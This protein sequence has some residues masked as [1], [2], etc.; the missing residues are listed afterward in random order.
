MDSLCRSASN[1]RKDPNFLSSLPQNQLDWLK[2]NCPQNL[3]I[4]FLFCIYLLLYATV[5]V[6]ISFSFYL[7]HFE[8]ITNLLAL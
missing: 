6:F 5:Q 7:V 8:K 1:L 2:Q 4:L 3:T